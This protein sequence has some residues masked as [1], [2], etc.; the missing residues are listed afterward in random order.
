MGGIVL[1][2]KVTARRKMYYESPRYGN[3]YQQTECASTPFLMYN[4][5]VITF[6]ETWGNLVCMKGKLLNSIER[7]PN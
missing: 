5:I 3:F 6:D 1:T 4:E 2:I 7:N